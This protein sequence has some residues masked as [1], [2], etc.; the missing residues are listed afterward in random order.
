MV[1]EG[2]QDAEVFKAVARKLRGNKARSVAAT[3]AEG[4]TRVYDLAVVLPP[5]IRI[6]RKTKTLA[7]L[8]DANDLGVEKRVESFCNSLSSHR[9]RVLNV[10]RM[11]HPQV[12]GLELEN[13][14]QSVFLAVNGIEEYEFKKHELEDHIVKLLELECK[15]ER[16]RIEAV[17]N[18]K[19]LLGQEG[20]DP[21]KVIEQANTENI[22]KALG[23]IALIIHY[24]SQ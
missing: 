1:C 8:V 12:F 13:V 20:I 19:E 10:V 15:V 22:I 21:V 7:F 4:I 2:K 24:I 23:H 5:L 9:I 6:S 17:N 11:K 18:A 16:R 14:R 3:H